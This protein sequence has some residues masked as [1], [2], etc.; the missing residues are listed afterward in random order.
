[1]D[2]TYEFHAFELGLLSQAH[3]RLAQH[4]NEAMEKLHLK[5]AYHEAQYMLLK[6]R[7]NAMRPASNDAYA[8]AQD[9]DKEHLVRMF[10]D[11]VGHMSEPEGD[12]PF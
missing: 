11:A 9:K 3:L 12:H 6:E 8:L 1:M 7:I 10:M 2:N 4:A 5:A